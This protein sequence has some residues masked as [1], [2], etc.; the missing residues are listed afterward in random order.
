[1]DTNPLFTMALGLVPPWKVTETRL[2]PA[3]Q[4]L[5]LRIGYTDSAHFPCPSCGAADC[6][7]YDAEEKRWRH[8]D[9]FQHH[10]F[11]TARV[12]RVTC[13]SC[14]VKT[15]A[16]PWAR[17]GSGFTLLME[18][19]ILEL[20]RQMPVRAIARLIGVRDKRLWRMIKHYVEQALAKVDLRRLR[21]IGV[22]ET[23]ARGWKSWTRTFP[24]LR[25][26][27]GTRHATRVNRVADSQDP[28]GP[29]GPSGESGRR[30]GASRSHRR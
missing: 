4:R 22:D 28:A 30:F 13:R 7:V 2:D 18:A 26:P 11:I 25:G 6:R 15:V 1:M 19:L 27:H 10:A 8:M 17:P 24:S 14:G 9:F 3:Q 5:D 29:S 20:A 23:S 16:V 12:P 21:R